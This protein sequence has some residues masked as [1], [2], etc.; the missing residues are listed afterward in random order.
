VD[1]D[2]IRFFCGSVSKNERWNTT[3]SIFFNVIK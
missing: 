3:I 1:V 2:D